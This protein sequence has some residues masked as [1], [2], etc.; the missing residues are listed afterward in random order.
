[1]F[2]NVEDAANQ[3][4]RSLS[5]KLQILEDIKHDRTTQINVA[6]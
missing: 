5:K 6:K 3:G 1:M 2:S 4:K